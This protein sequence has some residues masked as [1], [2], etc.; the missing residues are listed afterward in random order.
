MADEKRRFSFTNLFR[1]T[2]PKPEDR[3]IYNI[4]IQ[5]RQQSNI[6]TAPIIYHIVQNSVI[7]RTC[8]TQLKQEIFRR[9]YVWEKAYEARCKN[10]GKE[11]QRPVQE[12][13]RCGRTDLQLPDVEQLKYAEKFIEGY[14]N[15]SEQL[16]M[17][18][19]LWMMHTLF[20]LKNILLM[21]IKK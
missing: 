18:L 3:S 13:S 11:H 9:G 7:A 5:E 6:M 15:K 12:C 1:R 16:R 20:L 17:T 14:V 4:G 19:T 2:T 8:I 10:C 21:E